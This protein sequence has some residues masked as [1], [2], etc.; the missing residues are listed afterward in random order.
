MV[1]VGGSEACGTTAGGV[2]LNED[3]ETEDEEGEHPGTEE[4]NSDV[5]RTRFCGCGEVLGDGFP[6]VRL[7][8]CPGDVSDTP[9]LGSF[10]LDERRASCTKEFEEGGMTVA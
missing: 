6:V 8:C 7:H 4:E 10:K 5:R 9:L 2:D 3:G 1:E